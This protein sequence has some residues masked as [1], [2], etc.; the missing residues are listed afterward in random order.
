M[1]QVFG[2]RTEAVNARNGRDYDD[3]SAAQQAHCRLIAK[4]LYLRVD[5]RV[6]LDEGICLR[7]VGLRLVVVVVRDKVLDRVVG[8]KLSELI[9]QLGGKCF[10]V[11]KDQCR[12]LKLLN[13]PSGGCRLSGACSPE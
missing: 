2:G 7:H 10:V 5:R 4:P 11:S 9:D 8:Q 1:V 12:A 6:L 13:Q 3:V